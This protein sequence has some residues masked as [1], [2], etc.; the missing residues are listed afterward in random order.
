[1]RREHPELRQDFVD[2][3]AIGSTA[4]DMLC[5]NAELSMHQRTHAKLG[6][7]PA[8]RHRYRVGATARRSASDFSVG[9]PSLTRSSASGLAS[10][11]TR[12]LGTRSLGLSRRE[13]RRH[14]PAAQPEPWD[15]TLGAPTGFRR[16]KRKTQASRLPDASPDLGRNWR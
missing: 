7:P 3:P 5:N 9:S 14:T 11:A 12:D 13:V 16:E 10:L 15:R 8:S 1:M 2:G 6:S 4:S